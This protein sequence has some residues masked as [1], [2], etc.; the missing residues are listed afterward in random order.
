MRIS[1]SMLHTQA[2]TAMQRQQS[3][4]AHTQKQ[5]AADQ[6]WFSASDNPVGFGA[7]QGLDRTLAQ[8]SQYGSNAGAARHRL[9]TE[10]GALAE[11]IDVLQRVRELTLQAN[12]AGQSAESRATIALELRSLREQLLDISNRDD[13]QGRYIFAGSAD[14]TPPFSWS[15][16]A[17]IYSGDQQVRNA[18]IGSSRSVAEGDAGDAVFMNLRNGNGVFSV[19][20]G[21]T[22]AGSAQLSA[23][24]I[25]D[26]A[27]W[28][29]ASYSVSFSAGNYEVRDASNALVQ[30]GSY[31]AGAAIRFRGV[32]LSFSGT[33]ND[34]D[35]FSVAPS[36]NQDVLALVDKLAR[37]IDTPQN[38]AAQRAQWQTALQQGLSELQTAQNHFSDTRAAVGLRLAAAEGAVD[39]VSAQQL[40]AREALSELRDLDYAEAAT[41][42]QQQLTALQ[43]AQQT[44]IQIQGMSLF[45]YLR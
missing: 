22:N 21:A 8:L 25:V 28:D 29:G 26:A 39:Q 41:R 38:D 35:G 30:S 32:E 15:G 4:L 13:G 7:A 1:T 20:S 6:K 33:P 16:S 18:Q 45:D 17:A 27:A 40:H 11:G 3:D 14:G 10:E 24:R 34:G 19:T 44:Y 42:L 12:S 23:A 5:M 36:Q 9:L 37:L 31:S 2:L 43:A